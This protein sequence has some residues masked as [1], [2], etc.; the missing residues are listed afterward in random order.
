MVFRCG[1]QSFLPLFLPPLAFS[2]L[3]L[4]R[5]TGNREFKT[6]AYLSSVRTKPRLELCMGLQQ[7]AFKSTGVESLAYF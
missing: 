1:Q 2:R 4:L 6:W 7:P 3:S 5:N